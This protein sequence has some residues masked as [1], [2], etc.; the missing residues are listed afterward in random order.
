MVK[1]LLAGLVAVILGIAGCAR[2]DV[3]AG[4]LLADI[5]A[6]TGD[7]LLKRTT[8]APTRTP[9]AFAIDGRT[10]MGDLYRPGQTEAGALVL[11]PG[12]ARE[13]RDDPRL[14]A[15]ATALARVRF[16]VL[17]PDIPS[18]R[19]EEAG[20]ED[21]LPILDA[22]RWLA[23][24]HGDGAIGIG[25]VSFAVGP[26]VLAALQDPRVDMVI[27]IGGYYDLT[28]L[29]TYFTTGC[30][31][32]RPGGPWEYRKPNPYGKWVFVK[33]IARRLDDAGDRAL[34]AAIV[35]RKLADAAAPVG[36]LA[37]G[38]GPEGRR[39]MALLDNRDPDRVPALIA[40]LPP[41]IRARMAALDLS[42]RDLSG[43]HARL[44]L[45]HGRNDRIIPWTQSAELAQAAPS[46]ELALPDN[47]AH[48]NLKAG[49]P[50]DAYVLW[51][52]IADILAERDR[53]ANRRH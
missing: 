53:L 26:A 14:V 32:G 15:F 3:E 42:R 9:I 44:F 49:S 22:A 29:A 4:L 27:G 48:A 16:V 12:A 8:P 13:G 18:L 10:R 50:D 37:A 43:L 36:D 1:A 52:I 20:A 19:A 45:I 30:L 38:L 23:L 33:S 31:H 41:P 34:L 17:V 11:V 35:E 21:R 7:S 51:R 5:A 2:R 6:G 25:A 39:V 47:L 40:A 24:E 28:Q 46:A